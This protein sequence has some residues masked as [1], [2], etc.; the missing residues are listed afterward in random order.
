[1]R[2][3]F[4]DYGF[5]V[6]KDASGKEV[7]IQGIAKKE[8]TSVEEL[9]HYAEDAGE[10]EEAIAAITEPEENIVFVADGVIIR[11]PEQ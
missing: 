6:P 2:I 5:F 4:R 3:T 8:V 9:R 10:S 7:I 1:M 11:E